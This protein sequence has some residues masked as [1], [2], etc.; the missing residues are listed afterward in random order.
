MKDRRVELE[1]VFFSSVDLSR[2]ELETVQCECTGI[3]LTY[4]PIGTV[5]I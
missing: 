2:I 1:L 5:R 4:R 3:P